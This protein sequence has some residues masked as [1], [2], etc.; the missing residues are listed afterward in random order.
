ME[1]E[2]VQ[3]E[4]IARQLAERYGFAVPVI[5]AMPVS[6]ENALYHVV[7]GSRSWVLKLLKASGSFPRSRVAEHTDYEAQLVQALVALGIDTAAIHPMVDGGLATTIAGHPAIL[8][9]QLV[10]ALVQRDDCPLENIVAALARMHVVQLERPLAVDTGFHFDDAVMVWL[11]LFHSYRF[12]LSIETEITSVLNRFAP[13]V[14]ALNVGEQREILF[15]RTP[16]VHCHGDVSPRNVIM[17]S[18]GK[19]WLFDFNHAFYGPRLA[20]VVD[21]AFQF[22]L[23]DFAPF[24]AF[25]NKYLQVL[26][27]SGEELADMPDWI[28]LVGIMRLAKAVSVLQDPDK[29]SQHERHRERFH[30]ISAILDRLL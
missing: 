20:D 26:P 22:H 6:S 5:E 29:H 19:V 14:E 28:A 25:L 7:T 15:Y 17:D 1:N 21:G 30:R 3:V 27:L 16:S 8:F 23:A 11:P 10:G 24:D 4:D 2:P 12:D 13:L 9:E 18:A